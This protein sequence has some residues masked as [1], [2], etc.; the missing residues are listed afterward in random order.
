[1]DNLL[2][3]ERKEIELQITG[4]KSAV[5]LYKRNIIQF[6]LLKSALLCG[7]KVED[8][9]DAYDK[10][11]NSNIKNT[12]SFDEMLLVAIKIKSGLI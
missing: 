4:N 2:E 3:E 6:E 11:I 9:E 1:M 7:Y 5:D 12:I 10:Y 8:I